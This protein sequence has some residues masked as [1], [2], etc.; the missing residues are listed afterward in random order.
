MRE[1]RID[2]LTKKFIADVDAAL[3]N[4]EKEFEL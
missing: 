4:K 1:K 2:E 3:T